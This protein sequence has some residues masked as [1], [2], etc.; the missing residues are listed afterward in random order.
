M[1]VTWKELGVVGGPQGVRD[2]WRQREIGV[3]STDFTA[4]VGRHGVVVLRIRP[5][6]KR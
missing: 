1:G 3:F 4:A 5:V 2:V 6:I